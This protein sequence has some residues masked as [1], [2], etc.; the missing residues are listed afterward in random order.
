MILVWWLGPSVWLRNAVDFLFV[1]TMTNT[2][3]WFSSAICYLT[4]HHADYGC[5]RSIAVVAAVT[6][7]WAK[8]PS[9]LWWRE[10]SRTPHLDMFRFCWLSFIREPVKVRI[11]RVTIWTKNDRNLL[12]R[13]IA[14]GCLLI[15]KKKENP[16]SVSKYSGLL[17][18]VFGPI[19]F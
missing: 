10:R 9:A 6:P 13:A 19:T 12:F 5:S 14:S 7:T 1:S 17:V 15:W 8:R 2:T 4:T 3:I 18:N 16:R 11:Q